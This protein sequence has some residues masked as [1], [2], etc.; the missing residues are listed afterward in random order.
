MI[1]VLA[2]VG[3]LSGAA[4]LSQFP[5]FSQQYLQRLA[6]AVDELTAVVA[7]FDASA[8]GFGLTR[9]EAL[10]EM[11]SSPFQNQLRADM[12]GNIARLDRLRADYAALSGTAPLERLTMVWRMNDTDLAT[13]TW[14]D[15]QPALPLT[16]AGAVS[17]GIGFIG[18]WLMLSGMLSLLSWPFRRRR[19][20]PSPRREPVLRQDPGKLAQYVKSESQRPSLHRKPE[21]MFEM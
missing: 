1:R 6:G 9:T 3:G 13:R 19:K 15:F 8:E 14:A 4:G 10:Q 5:E 18:G 17:S 16:Q 2:L 21:E 7:A 11:G 12:E 20:Q